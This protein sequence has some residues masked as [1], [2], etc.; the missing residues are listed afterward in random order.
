MS[1]LPAGRTHIM[2]DLPLTKFTKNNEQP[3]L[4]LSSFDFQCTLENSAF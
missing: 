2:V 3:K 4:D 1:S